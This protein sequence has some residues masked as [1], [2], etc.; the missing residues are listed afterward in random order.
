MGRRIST[1]ASRIPAFYRGTYVISRPTP[2]GVG[3]VLILRR[4]V[5][6][7]LLIGETIRVVDGS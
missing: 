3:S 2:S 5:A 6:A 7:L 4:Y 1:G